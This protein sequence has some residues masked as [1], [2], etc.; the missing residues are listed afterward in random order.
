MIANENVERLVYSA[1]QASYSRTSP[2]NIN[3]YKKINEA[4]Q[5]QSINTYGAKIPQSSKVGGELLEEALAKF[6]LG[7]FALE[8]L[9]CIHHYL[10]FADHDILVDQNIDLLD[11]KSG[12]IFIFTSL[13]D[14]VLYTWRSFLDFYLK[15]LLFTVTGRKVVNI[16]LRSFRNSIEKHIK[17]FP[18]DHKAINIESYIKSNVLNTYYGGKKQCWGDILKELRDKTTHQKLIRPSFTLKKNKLGFQIP[19]LTIRNYSLSELAQW[20]F[21]N[22]AF[23]MLQELNPI[24]YGFEWKSGPYKPGMYK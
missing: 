1:Y 15:Y 2:H 12:I 16:S 18:N 23:K 20:E 6:C 11:K 5:Q 22:E 3:V 21:E 19:Y 4:H 14:Q 7:S 17:K 24:L 8:Q 10:E 9:W 13:L